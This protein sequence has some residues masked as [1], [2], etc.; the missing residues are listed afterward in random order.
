[1]VLRVLRLVLRPKPRRLLSLRVG[2]MLMLHGISSVMGRPSPGGS[3]F[4]EIGIGSMPPK[5][6]KW[7]RDGSM[8]PV[9]VI[10]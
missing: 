9:L 10:T 5:T 4:T 8:W 3:R 1:M 6:A 2:T 7:Q